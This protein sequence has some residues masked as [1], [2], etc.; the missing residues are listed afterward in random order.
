MLF[1]HII[2]I[3]APHHCLSCSTEGSLLCRRCL[4]S[5]KPAPEQCYRCLRP[6]PE[7]ITCQDCR[8]STHITQVRAAVVYTGYAR[9]LLWKLKS[10]RA[11][12]AAS[13]LAESCRPYISYQQDTVVSYIPTA[14]IRVR[15]RGYD[16]AELIAR[17]VAQYTNMPMI[18][19]LSRTST[20]RQVGATREVRHLQLQHAFRPKNAYILQQTQKIIL[21]DDVITTGSSLEAAAEVLHRA[22]AQNIVA[23]AFARA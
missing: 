8:K 4:T 18:P 19:L 21:I 11:R 14:P 10:E 23:V 12:A 6:S 3:I 1:E 22:G 15:Q 16:Q 5:L 7:G 17:T 13:L 2:S 9:D 20:A